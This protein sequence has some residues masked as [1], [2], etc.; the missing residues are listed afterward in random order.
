ML[1]HDLSGCM[2]RLLIDGAVTSV[3]MIQK[4]ILFI[5]DF[6]CRIQAI[7]QEDEIMQLQA[8]SVI[9]QHLVKTFRFLCQAS[10]GGH[11]LSKFIMQFEKSKQHQINQQAWQD[12]PMESLPTCSGCWLCR[13]G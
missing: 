5:S 6:S 7:I 10:T 13:C 1:W 9:C 2:N 8:H 3:M 12:R 4:L 11:L